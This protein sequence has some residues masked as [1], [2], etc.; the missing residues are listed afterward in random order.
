M[1]NICCMALTLF[2]GST[3]LAGNLWSQNSRG[4]IG[5]TINFGG[6][7]LTGE[8]EISISGRNVTTI[9]LKD[10][11]DDV[12]KFGL[13]FSYAHPVSQM[14]SIGGFAEFRFLLR[15]CEH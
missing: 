14:F 4:P 2:L 6:G 3:F 7:S 1:K 10:G 12:L 8:G 11:K 5:I 9:K 15:A 13:G